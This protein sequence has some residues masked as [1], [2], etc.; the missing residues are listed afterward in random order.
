[1]SNSG[2]S[3]LVL[4]KNEEKDL[5]GC[6]KS[7]AWSD[8][9]VV[10]DS[11]SEDS[12]LAVARAHGARVIQRKFDDW[13]THQNWGLKN[14]SFKNRWVFYIDADERLAPSGAQ[15]LLSISRDPN[16]LFNAYRLQRRDFLDGRWLKHVQVSSSYIRFFMPGFIRYERLVNPLTIVE[17]DVGTLSATYLDHYPFS[18]GYAHWVARHNSYSTYEALEIL[19]QGSCYKGL[20]L[21][22]G[23]FAADPFTRRSC[24]KKLFYS[25]PLRPL[26]KFFALYFLRLGFL[27]GRCGLRYSI[28][29]AFYEYL[30]VLKV[31]ELGSSSSLRISPS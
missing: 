30:I 8:D 5:P 19:S 21:S 11:F 26:I 2:V 15:E 25:L 28:L 27:D 29:Q 6:L 1:M 20:P 12:T 18:K 31:G 22:R 17:G 7:V 9:I 23:L 13:S 4:T 24:Q 10:Y 3:I 16:P 14:I